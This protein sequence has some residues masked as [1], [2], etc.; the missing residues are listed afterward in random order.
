[1]RRVPR[2]LATA[3]D[4]VMTVNPSRGG[5][6]RANCST[7]VPMPRNRTRTS[8]MCFTASRAISRFSRA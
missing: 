5:S 4:E 2:R 7:V 6:A 8:P 1:M 3:S